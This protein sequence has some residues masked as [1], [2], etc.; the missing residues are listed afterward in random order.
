MLQQKLTG[1]LFTMIGVLYIV[2]SSM[3]YLIFD[4]PIATVLGP[5]PFVLIFTVLGGYSIMTNLD[6]VETKDEGGEQIY[7]NA[8]HTAF[9]ISLPILIID[10]SFE[11]APQKYVRL[12]YVGILVT[13][14][15]ASYLYYK[16]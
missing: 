14:F 12:L 16:R 3:A 7:Q 5:A 1:Y 11:I 13:A 9:I 15:I 6:G 4:V 2:I 8:G 10:M